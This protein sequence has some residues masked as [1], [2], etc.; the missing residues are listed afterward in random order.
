M[1][2]RFYLIRHGAVDERWQGR[3]YGALEVPLSPLGE[4]ES[5]MLARRLAGVSFAAVLS[6]G[7]ARAEYLAELL[8][9]SR[10]LARIDERDLRELERGA[11]A[12]RTPA[13]LERESPGAWLAWQDAP[14]RLHPPGG[15][16]LRDLAARVLPAL[17]RWA[18]RYPGACLGVVTHSWVARVAAS[19][20]LGLGPAGAARLDLPTASVVVVDWPVP[21][22]CD[23]PGAGP[24]PTLV[25][26]ATRAPAPDGQR[27]FHAARAARH[28]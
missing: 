6:S 18:A 11:W 8:R 4:G 28:A 17:D 3:I 1:L 22:S 12:G 10:G 5:R 19:A 25:A 16:T 27:W 15:E 23:A 20:A 9:T 21:S 24:R 26:F 14:D 7:L 2:S 13:E